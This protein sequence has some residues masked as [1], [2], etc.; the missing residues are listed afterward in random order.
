MP[1]EITPEFAE[2]FARSWYAAWNACPRPDLAAIMSHYAAGIEHSSP[3]IARFNGTDDPSLRG[4]DAVREYFGRAIERSPTPANGG[5]GG[6]LRFNPM[7][8]TIGH[9]SVILVYR[10][11]SGELAAEMFVFDESGKVGRSVSHYGEGAG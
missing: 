2:S 3:F 7:H 4:I 11:F 6:P 9:A 10:R 8:V 1:G 5:P